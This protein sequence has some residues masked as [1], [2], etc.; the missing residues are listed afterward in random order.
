MCGPLDLDTGNQSY[1]VLRIFMDPTVLSSY[2]TVAGPLSSQP[3]FSSLGY[4]GYSLCTPTR[5]IPASP[6]LS[7][8]VKFILS[9]SFD[10]AA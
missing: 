2:P 8:K 10:R 3:Y 5:A 9:L 7:W 4:L 1:V 6:S